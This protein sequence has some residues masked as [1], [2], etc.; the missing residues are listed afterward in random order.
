MTSDHLQ[1]NMG[2]KFEFISIKLTNIKFISK[3]I[4]L[5]GLSPHT[6]FNSL[7]LDK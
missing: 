3:K 5:W 4:V 2:L 1:P 7:R 6:P